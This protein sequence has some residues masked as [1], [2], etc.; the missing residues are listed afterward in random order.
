MFINLSQVKQ[1]VSKLNEISN[2]NHH[3]NLHCLQ[4]LHLLQ[5]LYKTTNKT[6]RSPHLVVLLAKNLNSIRLT[7]WHINK[8]IESKD[9]KIKGGGLDKIMQCVSELE[10]A[11]KY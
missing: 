1:Y 5:F 9:N 10:L 6:I 3:T 2:H 4:S 8:N 7:G 11:D